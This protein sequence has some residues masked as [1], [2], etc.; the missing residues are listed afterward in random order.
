MKL[1]REKGSGFMFH[2]LIGKIVEIDKQRLP[3]LAEG[4]VINGIPMVLGGNV[5]I[6]CAR[7]QYRL[8]VAAVTVFQFIAPGPPGKGHQLIP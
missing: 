5:D 7:L 4:V 6:G 8:V 2:P 1:G 3:F